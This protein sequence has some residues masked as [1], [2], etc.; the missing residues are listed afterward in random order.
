MVLI[1][2]NQED[3]LPVFRTDL[4]NSNVLVFFSFFYYQKLKYCAFILFTLAVT[5]DILGAATK[6]DFN[7]KITHSA[8]SLFLTS[9]YC[10]V[11]V[12][13]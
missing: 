6:I 4:L 9:C 3:Q 2:R 1:P 7:C 13:R 8:V 10:R 12:G 11:S 5:V